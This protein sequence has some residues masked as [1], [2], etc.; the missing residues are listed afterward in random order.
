MLL[1]TD[2][3]LCYLPTLETNRGTSRLHY[4]RYSHNW[5]DMAST[6]VE[7]ASLGKGNT[8]RKSI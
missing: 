4:V 2:N 8:C 1:A 7:F 6:V 3:K 5:E